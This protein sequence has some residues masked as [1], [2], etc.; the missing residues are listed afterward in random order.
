MAYR[1]SSILLSSLILFCILCAGCPF[2]ED[3]GSGGGGGD[4]QSFD[5]DGD[6]Y[7]FTCA[8]G[9][10]CAGQQD[11]DCDDTDP[12]VHPG[13][14]EVC[15]DGVDQD[16]DGEDIDLEGSPCTDCACIMLW[17]PVCVETKD[18]FCYASNSS[19]AA[20]MCAKTVCYPEWGQDDRPDPNSECVK[21]HPGCENFCGW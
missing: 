20:L 11:L 13:R 3:R 2:F 4:L 21:N 1:I 16:C 6:G 12:G 8:G 10:E 19:C 7:W 17:G 9:N 14:T 5:M 15:G 18:G